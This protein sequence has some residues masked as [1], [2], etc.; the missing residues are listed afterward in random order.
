MIGLIIAVV[1]LLAVAVPSYFI[2]K[3][4]LKSK[5]LVDAA[6]A[7]FAEQ[8]GHAYGGPQSALAEDEGRRTLP[9]GQLVFHCAKRREG[10]SIVTTQSWWLTP[11][12]APRAS[13]RLVSRNLVGASRAIANLFGPHKIK[14]ERPHPGP[15]SLGDPGLDGRFALYADDPVAARAALL[16]PPVLQALTSFTS[17][18]LDV[19]PDGILF[20]DPADA[21]MWA[22]YE[23]AGLSRLSANPAPMIDVATRVH[24]AVHGLLSSTARALA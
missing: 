11:A 6:K 18:V 9:E 8:V 14:V 20:A 4:M 2:V 17:V 3:Q 21:N 13:F 7:R 22:A 23:A 16:Q 12:V 5:P 1:V 19:G 24:L 10:N 15:H